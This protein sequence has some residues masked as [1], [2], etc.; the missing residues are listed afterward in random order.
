M[1]PINHNKKL[2]STNFKIKNRTS[3]KWMEKL[4][5]EKLENAGNVINLSQNQNSGILYHTS[6]NV[7][8]E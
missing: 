2:V 6:V 8:Q 5:N 1:V 4:L 3:G 7:C